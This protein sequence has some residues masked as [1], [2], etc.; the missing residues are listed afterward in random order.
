MRVNKIELLFLRTQVTV[1]S[2]KLSHTIAVFLMLV[3]TT[4][5]A[6]ASACYAS[7][8]K[9]GDQ[10]SQM[11][12][13]GNNNSDEH[14]QH[15][16]KDSDEQHS[17]DACSMVGCHLAQTPTFATESQQFFFKKTS[18]DFLRFTSIAVS[19]DLPP[20]IKPPA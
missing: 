3:L 2:M 7:C 12:A 1:P 6:L 13:I 18:I 9:N 15:D 8:I 11:E 14:C 4:S 17:I 16:S 5:Q 10:H 20:P 19:A